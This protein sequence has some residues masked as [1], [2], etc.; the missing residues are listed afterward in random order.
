M[1]CLEILAKQKKVYSLEKY[2]Y[3]WIN[4]C[5]YF[6]NEPVLNC[7]II[8]N[9]LKSTLNEIDCLFILILILYSINQS[10]N[11][12]VLLLNFIFIDCKVIVENLFF[13]EKIHFF[14]K[15]YTVKPR[16]LQFYLF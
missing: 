7:F 3:W 10:I 12:D 2:D 14:K 8:E 11:W 6:V 1:F 16:Y 4:N 5:F 15:L 13:C 9:K